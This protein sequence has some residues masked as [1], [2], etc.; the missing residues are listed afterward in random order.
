MNGEFLDGIL[1][2]V[3]A[4]PG[5][6]GLIVFLTAMAESL[7][8]VGLVVPGAA[9]MFGFG[10]LVA[11]GHLDFWSACGWAVV[12]AVVGDGLSFWLGRAL[13]QR[14]RL[15]WP[16]S[17]HPRLLARGE[18]YFLRH[19]GKSV[20]FGRFFG[21]VR[22]VVPAVAGMM[23]MPLARFL[24]VNVV[25]ALLWAPAYLLPGMV[26][27]ASLELAAQVTLRLVILILLL[28]VVLWLTVRVVR[29]LLRFV[30]PRMSRW[31]HR[32]AV[33]SRER[34]V[35]GPVTAS[36]V[37]PEH[38]ELQGLAALA[39]LL[40][41]AAM[42]LPLLLRAAGQDL[43]TGLDRNLYRFLQ[44]LR[45]PWVDELMVRITA[46]GD[47][48][49][50]I[51]LAA[52]VLAWLLWRRAR[53]AALHWL[54]AVGFGFAL[55][56]LFKLLLQTSRPV[57]SYAGVSSYSFPSAHATMSTVVF[58]FL[59][60]L[61]A[62]ELVPERRWGPYLA[63]ALLV[64]PVAFSRLYLGVHWLS[65]TVA[66]IGLGLA[67]VGVLGLAY[68][69]HPARHLRPGALALVA[70]TTLVGT[71][72]VHASLRHEADLHRYR[73]PP[74]VETV[75]SV[76]EWRAQG[77]RDLPT[78]RQDFRGRRREPLAVQ[79]AA[80]REALR[81]HLDAGGWVAPPDLDPHSALRWLSPRA[82]ILSLPVLPRIHEGQAEDLALVR[83]GSDGE[84]RWV[85]RLWRTAVSLDT[86][87]GTGAHL[88][89]WVGSLSRQVLDRRLP[90]LAIPAER[91]A[92]SL[93]PL[94]GALAG[95]PRTERHPPGGTPVLLVG[96][97][98]VASE[99]EGESHGRSRR[100]AGYDHG[101]HGRGPG[102]LGRPGRILE[103]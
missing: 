36:L 16:F 62:R 28:I 38:G 96:P 25:S 17:R 52:T 48:V 45:T 79:W 101:D 46:L 60:V 10:A 103:G 94:D 27:A 14:L 44:D 77:W 31:L 98:A 73:P 20:L 84:G 75:V 51:A 33:W 1:A 99:H 56:N 49:T 15:L 5:W 23:D 86:P 41:G 43:P 22:A 63:A 92:P 69:R 50:V 82:E 72:A 66:G 11:L 80:T 55:A 32:F 78:H 54:A 42:F 37:D 74:P 67:W 57:A 18:A 68:N 7:A 26:F 24:V 83:P 65:D 95:L 91:T 4:H 100:H 76:L 34:P 71:G 9:M 39:A 12:G 89:I 88:P 87:S 97:A 58:G 3:N 21:P 102:T 47:S 2:W 81:R 6:M 61:V 30:Q 13:H 64:I 85:L 35:L 93:E 59:A 29:G 40:V 19:G 70:V 90:F 8:V 53:S